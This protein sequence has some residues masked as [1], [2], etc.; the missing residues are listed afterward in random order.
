[1]LKELTHFI[2]VN[3]VPKGKKANVE[4]SKT[5]KVTC[6]LY[7]KCLMIIIYNRNDMAITIKLQL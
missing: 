7:Y 4:G 3:L 6:S 1:M 5:S 2:P